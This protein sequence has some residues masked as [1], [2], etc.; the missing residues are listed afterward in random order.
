MM[1]MSE[2]QRIQRKIGMGEWAHDTEILQDG[3]KLHAGIPQ[4]WI[5]DWIYLYRELR[6][7]ALGNLVDEKIRVQE[8][9][10]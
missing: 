8:F 6:E 1:G 9:N 4:R 3:I 5:M 2:I 7:D 10:A